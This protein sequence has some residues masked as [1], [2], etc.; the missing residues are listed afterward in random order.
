MCISSWRTN[1]LLPSLLFNVGF[2]KHPKKLS[3]ARR[4][5]RCLVLMINVNK[6]DQ[7]IFSCRKGEVIFSMC[8]AVDFFFF[9]YTLSPCSWETE[10]GRTLQRWWV[11]WR[12]VVASGICWL[13]WHHLVVLGG[14]SMYSRA[15][16]GH[17]L[18][19]PGMKK[20]RGE[21][22]KVPSVAGTVVIL[23]ICS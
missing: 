20:M 6:W 22:P 23:L 9:I 16:P 19:V 8:Y 13:L 1:R 14:K 21:T 7:S 10:V 17:A 11:F 2:L 5:F 3:S 15:N 12:W 4:A 18:V